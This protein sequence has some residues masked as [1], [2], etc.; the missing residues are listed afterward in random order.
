MRVGGG[1]TGDVTRPASRTILHADLDSF[2]ASVEQRDVPALRG[3]PV[4]VGMG[5]VTAASYEAKRR[6]VTTPMGI[7]PALRRCPDAVVVPPRMDAYARASRAV[8]AVFDDI[9]P[10]VEGLSIDEAFL[11]VTG[12]WRLAGDSRAIAAALRRRV[13]DEVGLPISVGV[14][15]TKFLAK[16]ASAVSKPDGLLVVAPGEELAFLRPLPI[17]R[18]WGVGPVTAERLA[19]RGLTTVADVADLAESALV[20]MVG[21]AAA[22]HL[23]ALAHNLDPRPVDT[24][25]RRRSM[26]S[27][28]AFPARRAAWGDA[29]LVLLEVVDRVTARLRT[30][31]LLGRTVVLRLRY[32]D[33]TGVTRS[34][35]MPVATNTTAVV[36]DAARTLMRSAWPEVRARGLSKVGVAVSG[37]VPAA[38]TQ[39]TIPFGGHDTGRLDGA[40]D[41]VRTRFGAAAV[42]R[43]ALIGRRRHDMPLLGEWA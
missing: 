10:E 25:R 41:Q 14:A 11:D 8:F 32:G 7:G 36:L 18:L 42:G 24:G 39:L 6:G 33:L 15:S 43:A 19:A 26:G 40:V 27:Q 5:V 13:A 9:T 30:A 34:H 21:V 1:H 20:A 35:T 17:R 4:L 12:L 31:D 22:R 38:A 28:R 23:R 37:L 2:Y 29:E 16:V 3:R